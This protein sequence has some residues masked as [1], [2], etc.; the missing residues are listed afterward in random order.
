MAYIQKCV[1]VSRSGNH[2]Q[3]L[4][5][6]GF[7]SI[8]GETYSSLTPKLYARQVKND[9]PK[10]NGYLG[11]YGPEAWGYGIELLT[12]ESKGTTDFSG[13]SIQTLKLRTAL[14]A[15]PFQTFKK[16]K[17]YNWAENN[18]ST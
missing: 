8:N 6:L 10:S 7:G 4:K 9:L 14:A 11:S 16:K 3:N 15:C 1:Y 2:N 17:S 13:F 12:H 5:I 18:Y